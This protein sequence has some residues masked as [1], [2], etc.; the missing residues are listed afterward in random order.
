[1]ERC[2]LCKKDRRGSEYGQG[3]C[4]KECARAWAVVSVLDAIMMM[5]ELGMKER[6]VAKTERRCSAV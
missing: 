4:S 1:M 3:C 6:D 2:S 5:L